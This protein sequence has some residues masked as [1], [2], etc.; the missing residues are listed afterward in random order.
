[1]ITGLTISANFAISADGKITNAMHRP[2][3]W[4]SEVD[5]QRLLALRQQADAIIVGKNTLLADNMS[6]QVPD[7][8]IQPLRCV[9]SRRGDYTGDE[10]L[11]HTP[12]GGAIHL[13]CTER[14]SK[15]Q[16]GAMMHQGAVRDFVEALR[17]HHGVKQLH[18]EGGGMLFRELLENVGV[19]TIYITWAAHTLFGGA[20][21]PTLVGIPGMPLRSSNQYVLTSAEADEKT[22]EVYLRYDAQ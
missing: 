16:A 8:A 22:G 9:V 20:L 17:D 13:L 15:P 11:F 19:H 3:G 21:S 4:T 12:Q 2:S 1:M 14:I 7:R 10:K 6:L 5:H 18:C